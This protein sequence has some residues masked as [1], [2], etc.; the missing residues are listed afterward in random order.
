MIART[1][2][3]KYLW[4]RDLPDARDHIY[5]SSTTRI[6]TSVDYRRYCSPIDDQGQLGSCTGNAIAGAIN[7]IDNKNNNR[8]I[9]VSRMFIY[10]QERLLEGTTRIDAGAYIR[11]GIRACYTYGAP[12]ET[13]WPYNI[14]LFRSQPTPAAYSDALN[15]KVTS[16]QRCLTLSDIKAALSAGYPVVIGFDVYESFE[17]AVVARTGQMP[18]PNKRR[19]Q[20]LGGHAVCVVGYQDS[21][22]TLICR[23]SWGSGWGDRGY[24]YM[25]Y[26]VIT[27]TS[28]SSDFWA[29]DAVNS[30]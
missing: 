2:V 13:L 10:Y 17:S 28:M 23:N 3:N 25:P 19:E 21:N 26:A 29:V 11:D 20:L 4:R 8:A 5:K 27:D 7:L 12:L 9:R 18:Y 22:S 6:P 24:F 14:G 15:R 1:T 30:R 16:Y